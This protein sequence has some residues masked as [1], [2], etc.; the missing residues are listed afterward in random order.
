MRGLIK[1]RGV[2]A[3]ITPTETAKS[4][5]AILPPPPD[6]LQ[7]YE[8]FVKR[9]QLDRDA[10]DIAAEEQ[11]QVFQEVG[12]RHVKTVSLRDEARDAL[13]RMDSALARDHRARL[14]RE[15]KKATEGI[16]NDY[17]L[18]DSRHQEMTEELGRLKR[19]A[20]LWGTLREAFEHRRRMISELVGLYASNYYAGA[21]TAR[22]RNA[23]R[24]AL[25]ER[26][27]AA[28]EESRRTR[29]R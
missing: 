21:G 9:I 4:I 11:A 13:A 27:R 16:V 10:L 20:D 8:D 5:K 24:D 29:N 1:P 6:P 12:E 26:G 7:D 22:P 15:Q 25:A 18:L 2:T 17:V 28:L 19:A 14:E 3:V 23:V